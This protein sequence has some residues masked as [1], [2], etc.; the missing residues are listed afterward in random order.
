MV[1]FVKIIKKIFFGFIFLMFFL[2]LLFY[3]SIYLFGNDLTKYRYLRFKK[4]EHFDVRKYG[5]MYPTFSWCD[6]K[7]ALGIENCQKIDVN[8]ALIPILLEKDKD[9]KPERGMIV[10]I[11]D[12]KQ[13]NFLILR[14]IALPD[15]T[16]KLNNG[17]VYINNA[18]IDEPYVWKRG[19]TYG[20]ENL[21]NC[22]ELKLG[23]NQV[24]VM[25]DNRI[26]SYFYDSR[27]NLGP[28]LIENITHYLPLKFQ[29]EIYKKRWDELANKEVKK[30][31]Y[32][33]YEL[34]QKLIEKINEI[35][36]DKKL[37]EV[38]IDNGLLKY[39]QM[40][41]ENLIK[42]NLDIDKTEIKAPFSYGNLSSNEGLYRI[43]LQGH[44]DEESYFLFINQLNE[45]FISEN[46]KRIGIGYYVDNNKCENS[47]TVFYNVKY[48]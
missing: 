15:E 28:V 39:A 24:F 44:Y 13:N 23:K 45:F 11:K 48:N 12:V 5:F 25:G 46:T 27:N 30:V 35:R 41:A 21:K 36:K 8:E 6:D 2:V 1:F 7:K 32:S 22:E 19:I 47:V 31:E 10:R 26:I 14:I 4:A 37:Q 18:L 43:L 20:G 38:T 33:N 34:N 9:F 42:E 40:I 29:K 17:Y 16:I 3:L